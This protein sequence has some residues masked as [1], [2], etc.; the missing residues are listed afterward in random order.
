LT[1]TAIAIIWKEECNVT[2][3]QSLF[4]FHTTFSRGQEVLY[5]LAVGGRCGDEMQ[6]CL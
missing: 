5:K 6:E 4:Q 2:Q 3:F 1:S